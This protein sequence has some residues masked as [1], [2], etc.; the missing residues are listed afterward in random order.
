M[1]YSFI[2]LVAGFVSKLVSCNKI[3]PNTMALEKV[4]QIAS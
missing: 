2:A 1:P 4:S 3:L